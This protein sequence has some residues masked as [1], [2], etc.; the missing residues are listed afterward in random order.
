MAGIKGT[1]LE[2]G[3]EPERRSMFGTDPLIP[4]SLSPNLTKGG[5]AKLRENKSKSGC[6]YIHT[7]AAFSE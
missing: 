7:S 6:Y 1:W 2:G 4:A 5:R 3:G